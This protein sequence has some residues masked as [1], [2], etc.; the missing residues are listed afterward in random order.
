MS[1]TIGTFEALTISGIAAVAASSGQ[2]TRTMSAPA[3]SSW[4]TCSMVA[5]ASPVTVLVIDWTV[6]GASPP[7]ATLPTWICRLLRRSI[8]RQGRRW[9]WSC[10]VM[11]AS[12]IGQRA[13]RRQRPRSSAG[14]FQRSLR[15][16]EDTLG[17]A[18]VEEFGAGGV[19]HLRGQ[20]R[21][22]RHAV[23]LA[24]GELTGEI[25][26]VAR[27]AHL[28]RDRLA[29]LDDQRRGARDRAVDGS[30]GDER[31]FG[32]VG[33][34]RRRGRRRSVARYR[35]DVGGRRAG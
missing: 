34:R 4:R 31:A 23:G 25:D 13:P 12:R 9:V 27:P 2:E 8:A 3:S 29:R 14:G 19:R 7:T 24:G 33:G 30:L 6:I 1:A 26:R 20:A 35:R 22:G 17:D 11:T 28:E 21:Q 10:A 15:L 5:L 32:R 18:A 16:G